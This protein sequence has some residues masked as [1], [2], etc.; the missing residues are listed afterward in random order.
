MYNL[1][2]YYNLESWTG[3]YKR[4]YSI[5]DRIS[6]ILSSAIVHPR[7]QQVFRHLQPT[8]FEHKDHLFCL[9]FAGIYA[10]L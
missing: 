8:R 4:E 2:F 6:I 5:I 3:H 1:L 7:M 10:N 9:H